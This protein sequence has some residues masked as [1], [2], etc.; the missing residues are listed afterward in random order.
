MCLSS[1]CRGGPNRRIHLSTDEI[2]DLCDES[3]PV[4]TVAKIF[5]TLD[6]VITV[7]TMLAHLAG[8][9]A[10]PVWTLL[11]YECDWR[12]MMERED[13]PWY[14]TMRL[15]RQPRP[16]DW[17]PVIQRVQQALENLAPPCPRGHLIGVRWHLPNVGLGDCRNGKE[18]CRTGTDLRFHP[19]SPTGPRN[20][21]LTGG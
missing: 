19:D 9:M 7:D 12:W 10:R 20:D 8:A 1:V 6:L 2:I 5:K 4:L 21:L 11:P 15:F 13:S 16:G 18:E 3:T 17:H 14:P